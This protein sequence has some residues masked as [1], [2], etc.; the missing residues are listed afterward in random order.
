MRRAKERFTQA[1][2][3]F[4]DEVEPLRRLVAIYDAEGAQDYAL[5]ARRTI[6][7]RTKR[8]P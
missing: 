1:R 2:D 8:S 4:P 6:A 3:E 5:A 7:E